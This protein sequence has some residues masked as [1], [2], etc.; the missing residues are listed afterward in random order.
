MNLEALRLVIINVSPFK[1]IMFYKHI[2]LAALIFVHVDLLYKGMYTLFS[3]K[4]LIS[5]KFYLI[6]L[7]S[8]YCNL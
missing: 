7:L 8:L 2:L 6:A 1:Q 4:K 3:S 5:M